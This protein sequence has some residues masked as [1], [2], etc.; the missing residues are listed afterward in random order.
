MQIGRLLAPQAGRQS[1]LGQ[2]L[3]RV[4]RLHGDSIATVDRDHRQTWSAYGERVSRLAGALRRLG[5]RD[6]ERVAI[7]SNNSHRYLEIYHAVPWAGAIFAP[8]NFRL[9][10]PEQA[11]ILADCGA[12][13]LIADNDHL[14]RA[15][16]LAH[17]L[18]DLRLLHAGDAAAP[19][20][21]L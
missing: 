3:A 9:A 17:G 14:E 13:I 15:S 1:S 7:L 11:A 5:L 2:T 4:M 16:Q 20:G 10:A 8:L 12:R 19:A 6:G 21:W 18:P